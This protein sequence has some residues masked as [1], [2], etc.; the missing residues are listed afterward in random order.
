MEASNKDIH[1]Q[2]HVDYV[3]SIR[4]GQRVKIF[5]LYTS[6]CLPV[7]Y[8]TCITALANA[9]TSI[10][11]IKI[12]LMNYNLLYLSKGWCTYVHNSIFIECNCRRKAFYH[13]YTHTHTHIAHLHSR[14]CRAKG[15]PGLEILLEQ[16]I[17]WMLVLPAFL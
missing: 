11:I 8:C 15:Q 16:L 9:C 14:L 12:F 13:T 2:A 17:Q 7:S 5:N 3:G 6:L 4:C 1:M 10:I